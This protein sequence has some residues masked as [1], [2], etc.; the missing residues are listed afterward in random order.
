MRLGKNDITLQYYQMTDYHESEAVK[1]TI[2]DS[3]TTHRNLLPE[4]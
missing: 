1:V 3:G 4:E 2:L